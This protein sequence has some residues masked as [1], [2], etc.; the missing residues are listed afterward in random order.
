MTT[1]SGHSCCMNCIQSFWDEEDEKKTHS[2]PQCGQT[3]TTRPVLLRSTMLAVLA[4]EL[5]KLL[6]LI[7]AMLDLKVWPVISALGGN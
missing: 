7:A 5:K 1:A 4:E 3:F 6:L 2:C